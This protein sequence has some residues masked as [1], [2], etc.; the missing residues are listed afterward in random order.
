M[1][2][3]LLTAAMSTALAGSGC[4]KDRRPP[5]LSTVLVPSGIFLAQTLCSGEWFDRACKLSYAPPIGKSRHRV[6]MWLDAFWADADLVTR[7][8]YEACRASGACPVPPEP[9]D[10]AH[11]NDTCGYHLL[12]TVPFEGALDYCRWRGWRLPTHDE[13]ERMAR[14]TDGRKFA[15]GVPTEGWRTCERRPS[16]EGIRSLNLA[17]QWV[18]VAEHPALA[19]GGTSASFREVEP[20]NFRA[21]FRCVRSVYPTPDP[22]RAKVVDDQSGMWLRGGPDG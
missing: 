18:A 21:P 15:A 6:R 22:G 2:A 17:N 14:W 1:R 16:P 9:V 13:F 5:L 8:D 20:L 12:A 4:R 7:A 10:P 11:P 3:L 19:G